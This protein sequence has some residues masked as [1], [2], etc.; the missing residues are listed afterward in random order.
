MGHLSFLADTQG[1]SIY[2]E[3]T[4]GNCRLLGGS[5]GVVNSLD[6]CPA[7][8]KSLG[9][10]CLAFTRMPGENYVFRVLII[11]LVCGSCIGPRGLVLF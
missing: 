2:I 5:S 9:V 10:V 11:S 7:S 3:Q 1:Q 4:G 6:F 8:L